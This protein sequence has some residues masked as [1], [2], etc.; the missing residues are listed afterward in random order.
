MES[1][2][3]TLKRIREEEG[4][5]LD[6]MSERT[7]VRIKF[8]EALE[9]DRYEIFPAATY[10]IGFLRTYSRALELNEDEVLLRYHESLGDVK[11]VSSRLWDDDPGGDRGKRR[12]ILIWAVAAAV[13]LLA[14]LTYYYLRR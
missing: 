13:V 14:A 12:P 2:G 5:T 11:T 8:L 9:E 1:L 3:E 10:V 6:E 4:V 7:R